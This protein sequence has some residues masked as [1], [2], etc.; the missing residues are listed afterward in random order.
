VIDILTR[1][2]IYTRKICLNCYHYRYDVFKHDVL[3]AT[4]SHKEGETSILMKPPFCVSVNYNDKACKMFS[5]DMSQTIR[6]KLIDL[7]KVIGND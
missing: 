4:C 6:S 3:N 1:K 5:N 2:E 7:K